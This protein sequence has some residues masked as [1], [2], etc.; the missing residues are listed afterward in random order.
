MNYIKR[1]I[2][3]IIYR[4]KKA[5][6]EISKFPNNIELSWRYPLRQFF[7]TKLLIATYV[8]S[9]TG[10]YH[11]LS[12]D[13]IDEYVIQEMLG[14]GRYMFFPILPK[15]VKD[16][17][18]NNG[19]I[20]DVGAYNG[21]WAM[22][23]LNEHAN[24]EVIFVEPSQS[25]CYNIQKSLNKN[26][27][28]SKTTIVSAGI[29]HKKGPAWLV[30]SEY[31]SWGDWLEYKKPID[32]KETIK[33]ETITL[34]DAINNKKPTII[35]C[36]AEGGEF[37]LIKQLFAANLRPKFMVLMIHPEMGNTDNLWE[38]L[39]QAGYSIEIIRKSSSRPVWHA[40]WERS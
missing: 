4:W 5:K 22:E 8:K 29:A 12:S 3:G 9:S 27:I 11:Y 23:L 33:V 34:L 28:N 35:K 1:S 2:K 26:K 39:I 20:L 15:C 14:E 18:D 25:R 21:S 17:L 10:V 31:G 40:K 6:I 37:E 32:S 19:V 38:S 16:E 30:M 13:L 36:N 7:R 24:A